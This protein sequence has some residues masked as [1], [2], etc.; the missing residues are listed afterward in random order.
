[1]KVAPVS[2]DLL[3]KLALGVVVI[4][5]V[6]YGLKKAKDVLGAVDLSAVDPTSRDNVAYQTANQIG[7]SLVTAPDGNGKNADG[8]WSLGGWIY[9]VTHP[10]TVAAIKEMTTPGSHAAYWKS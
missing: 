5:A 4:G 10:S 1:M 3:V 8:S 9:D 2:A 6:V 7:G